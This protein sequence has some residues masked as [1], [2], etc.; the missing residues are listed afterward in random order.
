VLISSDVPT[1]LKRGSSQR[2]THEPN[3]FLVHL[4]L[5]NYF[6]RRI[7]FD[8]PCNNCM[9]QTVHNFERSWS[10]FRSRRE[11]ITNKL[12]LIR[13][14]RC[15]FNI[16]DVK[17]LYWLQRSALLEEEEYESDVSPHLRNEFTGF[18]LNVATPF[19][20]PFIQKGKRTLVLL[21]MQ[22]LPEYKPPA[23]LTSWVNYF[24]L[25]NFEALAHGHG[26]AQTRHGSVYGWMKR[27]IDHIR[28][29]DRNTE[30][31]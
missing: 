27:K 1:A 12:H 15:G 18:K 21:W 20:T 26:S 8:S 30:R 29:H 2:A 11:Q 17:Y 6:F 9:V 10:Y 19:S 14:K 7:L 22:L 4:W 16:R 24:K 25:R 31:S 28:W 23:F 5:Q 13:K 3:N